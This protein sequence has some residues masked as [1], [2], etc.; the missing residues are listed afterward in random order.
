MVS[1]VDKDQGIVQY[2]PNQDFYGTDV[3]TYTVSDGITSATAR[4][5]I[6]VTNVNDP[7]T[8][9]NGTLTMREDEVLSINASDYFNDIDSSDLSLDKIFDEQNGTVSVENDIVNFV[10]TENYNGPGGFKV[11][12]SDDGGIEATSTLAITITAVNDPPILVGDSPPITIEEEE[13]FR[14]LLVR[15]DFVRDVDNDALS[16]TVIDAPQHKSL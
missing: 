16:A 4:V 10:P 1:I 9:T 11:T 14:L 13:E 7:P 3:F 2:E 8:A 6:E 15:S 5:D 12:I